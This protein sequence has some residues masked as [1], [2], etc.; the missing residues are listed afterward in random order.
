MVLT[1]ARLVSGRGVADAGRP[2]K[3]VG[4]RKGP[5]RMRGMALELEAWGSYS[6]TARSTIAFFRVFAPDSFLPFFNAFL[7]IWSLHSLDLPA[8][9][10]WGLQ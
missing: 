1:G 7:A 9:P 6:L 8:L 10:A 4:R 3:E 5:S 2:L